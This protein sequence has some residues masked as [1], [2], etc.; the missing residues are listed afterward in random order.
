MSEN[1]PHLK[2]CPFCGSND[3]ILHM[4]IEE[5]VTCDN[6]QVCTRR[7]SE[8]RKAIEYW[9]TRA[10]IKPSDNR[11]EVCELAEKIF[12][13]T[14]LTVP[15]DQEKARHIGMLQSNCFNW[16]KEFIEARDD[17]LKS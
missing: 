4:S 16:A 6:C 15:I 5:W 1:S 12:L 11:K 9:N 17:Y 14:I 10:E 3:L 2:S 13:S 8:A 7:V